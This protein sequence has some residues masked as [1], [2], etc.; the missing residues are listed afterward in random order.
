[1]PAGPAMNRWAKRTPYDHLWLSPAGWCHRFPPTH[2]V[3]SAGRELVEWVVR[4]RAAGLGGVTLRDRHEITG[5]TADPAGRTITGVRVRSREGGHHLRSAAVAGV[6]TVA[7]SRVCL[8]M[9]R[10]S[11]IST[12]SPVSSGGSP[13]G[14]NMWNWVEACPRSRWC[15]LRGGRVASLIVP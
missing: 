7:A 13:V 11:L 3:P 14:P 15:R 6:T 5:L 10:C 9:P 2:T 4:R 12:S 8:P 1:M